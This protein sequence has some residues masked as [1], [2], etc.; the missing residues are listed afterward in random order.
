MTVRH[1]I[2]SILFHRIYNIIFIKYSYAL[3]MSSRYVVYYLRNKLFLFVLFKVSPSFSGSVLTL[4]A[5]GMMS[6]SVDLAHLRGKDFRVAVWGQAVPACDCGE[7]PARWLSR[8]LLQEDVGLRLVYYTLDHSTRDVREINK[9]FPL[10]EAIDSVSTFTLTVRSLKVTPV[11][12]LKYFFRQG[13]Y[14]DVTSYTLV[15][16]A[17][18]TDL[19]NR[20]EEPITAQQFRMNFVVKGAAAFEE[21]KWDWIKIGNVIFR[22]VKPCIRCIFTTI[23]PETGKKNVKVEPLKTL[24][25]Y[26]ESVIVRRWHLVYNSFWVVAQKSRL[27]KCRKSL[28]QTV[29]NSMS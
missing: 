8:F 4:R 15:T 23:D 2:F 1:R 27:I 25:R 13:A 29:S 6:I 3:S 22:N 7:E 17:S 28:E 24:K 11:W 10:T 9:V 26:V 18:I 19:N 5:P 21:D 14:P 20:L 12:Y 16:E